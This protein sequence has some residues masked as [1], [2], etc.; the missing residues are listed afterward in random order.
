M[1][2]RCHKVHSHDVRGPQGYSPI[3]ETA[4]RA[5]AGFLKSNLSP[6][7]ASLKS[8]KLGQAISPDLCSSEPETSFAIAAL[9]SRL[10]VL[11][12]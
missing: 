6:L 2:F 7:L 8:D 9:F 4:R 3:Y 10:T 11:A 12:L 1:G 5:S